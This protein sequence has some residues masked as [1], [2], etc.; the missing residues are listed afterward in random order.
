M[1]KGLR[2]DPPCMSED[3]LVLMSLK[4]P[5]EPMSLLKNTEIHVKLTWNTNPLSESH[6]RVHSSRFGLQAH[7]SMNLD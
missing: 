6:P 3:V 1:D 2:W 7:Y 5:K 4:Y